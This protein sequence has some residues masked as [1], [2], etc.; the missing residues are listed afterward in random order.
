MNIRTFI[1]TLAAAAVLA[2]AAVTVSAEHAHARPRID[3]HNAPCAV[4][5]SAV[6]S[7]NDWEFYSPG[8]AIV[9]GGTVYYCGTYGL[10]VAM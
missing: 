4:S 6:G 10:M 8:D 7:S 1:R 5:G 3:D 2:V 9:F